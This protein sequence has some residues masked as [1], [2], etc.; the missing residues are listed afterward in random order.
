MFLHDL[1][2]KERIFQGTRVQFLVL[3]REDMKTFVAEVPYL[4]ISVTDP[5]K[6]AAEIAE[7]SL[8]QATLRMKFHDVGK[9]LRSIE[10]DI[11]S[12]A[13]DVSMTDKDAQQILSF[14]G[15]NLNKIRLIVCHCEQGVSRS[16]AI[17]AALSKVLQDE[18]EFFFKNYWVN[19]WVY[20]LLLANTDLLKNYS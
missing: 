3:N 10:T 6:H 1:P 13:T 7:S 20:D 8:L 18:D 19:R 17:A 16:A 5:E 9:P 4:V 14:V 12:A 2:L 11:I 15:E